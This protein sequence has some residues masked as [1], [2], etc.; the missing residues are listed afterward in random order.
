MDNDSWVSMGGDGAAPAPAPEQN[1]PA[2]EQQAPQQ[3]EAVAPAAAPAPVQV[4]VVGGAPAPAQA[5]MQASPELQKQVTT[6]CIISLVCHYV[7]LLGIA[8]LIST[9][10][11]VMGEAAS[12]SI[13]GLLST[14][15]FGAWIASWVLMIVART[16][17]KTR[18][19]PKVLMW[20]YIIELILTI[21]AIIALFVFFAAM[22]A[23][24]AN[25]SSGTTIDG[26]QFGV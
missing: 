1:Q 22:V 18:T 3:V 6:L 10:S 7:P 13:S 26:S 23:S 15:E 20:V 17:D 5:Q 25:A 24:C 12:N 4:Q 2:P 21:L 14:L 11:S 19:F 9:L 16:K 8:S